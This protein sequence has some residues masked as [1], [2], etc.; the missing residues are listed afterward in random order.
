MKTISEFIEENELSME[1]LPVK[2]RPDQFVWSPD[3]HHYFI[4]IRNKAGKELHTY[5]STGSAVPVFSSYKS[6]RKFEDI[7][8]SLSLDCSSASDTFEDFCN[9]FGYE[10]DSRKAYE[11][12]QACVKIKKDMERLVGPE[13]LEELINDVE[14]L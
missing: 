1:F 8:D 10:T 11:T 4:V 12:W 6:R 7:M 13:A 2:E 9:E 14:R 5:Y 3:A